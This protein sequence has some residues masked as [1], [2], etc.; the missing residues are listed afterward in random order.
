M[1]Y[2]NWNLDTEDAL[3]GL[4]TSFTAHYVPILTYILVQIELLLLTQV[5]LK[6]CFFILTQ[7]GHLMLQQH[8]ALN[9][10]KMWQVYR[11]TYF[12]LWSG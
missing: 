2:Q 4:I 10:L 8:I 12:M 5:T 6:A 7:K 11:G 1:I 3:S 9:C